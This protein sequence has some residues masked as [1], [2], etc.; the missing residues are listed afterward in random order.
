MSFLLLSGLLVGQTVVAS[1]VCA[2]LASTDTLNE[3]ARLGVFTPYCDHSDSC[4]GLTRHETPDEV[5]TCD[6]AFIILTN[7]NRHRVNEPPIVTQIDDE[8]HILYDELETE[9]LSSNQTTSEARFQSQFNPNTRSLLES[10]ATA[11][12]KVVERIFELFPR[13]V[14]QE[15]IDGPLLR[16]ITHIA[17]SLS[18]NDA[19]IAFLFGTIPRISKYVMQ[20]DSMR[21]YARAIAMMMRL[22][23]F[24]K[25]R[26]TELLIVSMAPWLH[27]Y[28]RVM[29]DLRIVYPHAQ[30][31]YEWLL[32]T[33]STIC[34]LY[35]EGSPSTWYLLLDS[36]VE[37]QPFS[38]RDRSITWESVVEVFGADSA[39][40][41]DGEYLLRN[42][43]SNMTR[44]ISLHDPEEEE[45]HNCTNS[46]RKLV[47]AM[48]FMAEFESFDFGEIATADDFCVIEDMMNVQT[49]NADEDV[50]LTS[51]EALMRLFLFGLNPYVLRDRLPRIDDATDY[52]PMQ[53]N[54]PGAALFVYYDE[55]GIRRDRLLNTLLS[56]TKHDFMMQVHLIAVDA[57]FPLSDPRELVADMMDVFFSPLT[58]WFEAEYSSDDSL[59]LLD[60][61]AA[62]YRITPHFANSSPS[63]QVA[64]GRLIGFIL[65]IRN[66]GNILNKYIKPPRQDSTIFE[67]LF[68][69]SR[70]IRQGFYDIYLA[71]SLEM[72]YMNGKDFCT[73]LAQSSDL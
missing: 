64:L 47:Y 63:N 33:A 34:P 9:Y 28:F 46:I 12:E 43:I 8:T 56:F 51:M 29:F 19:V 40:E 25:I 14:Y 4:V 61:N 10:F 30:D 48:E 71:D 41:H 17:N 62:Y 38:P 37:P 21:K 66:P 3:F 36:T 16:N 49:S 72:S 65:W 50:G 67:T 52:I 2:I 11:L 6:D 73:V 58:G 57:D 27:A 22:V 59:D 60:D 32:L 13:M 18:P 1:D 7:R 44:Y 55:V 35:T 70:Y 53:S 45:F 5:I 24:R 31:E 20:T 42:L 68:F 23:S 26:E 15:D 69:G 39:V 54:S